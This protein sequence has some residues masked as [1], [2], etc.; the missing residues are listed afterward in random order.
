MQVKVKLRQT[1]VQESKAEHLPGISKEHRVVID[2]TS[3]E[4]P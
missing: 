3:M 4:H 1:K 2:K